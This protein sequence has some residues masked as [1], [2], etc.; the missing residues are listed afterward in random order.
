MDSATI[1]TSLVNYLRTLIAGVFTLRFLVLFLGC[2]VVNFLYRKITNR[3][4]K[5][6]TVFLIAFLGSLAV[7]V[8]YDLY[9][10]ISSKAS[11]PGTAFIFDGPQKR[12]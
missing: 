6:I 3:A 8:L 7:N 5:L 2:L 12:P 4:P 10:A 9:E 1:I 11:K